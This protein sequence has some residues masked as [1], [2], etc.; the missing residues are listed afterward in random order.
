MEKD[1]IRYA[2]L[3]RMIPSH[4]KKARPSDFLFSLKMSFPS[5]TKS[6]SGKSQ[7]QFHKG[8]L[9]FLSNLLKASRAC[10][11]VGLKIS[12]CTLGNLNE[13]GFCWDIPHKICAPCS[14]YKHTWILCTWNVCLQVTLLYFWREIRNPLGV[15]LEDMRDNCSIISRESTLAVNSASW[16][17]ILS[18][19]QVAACN[20]HSS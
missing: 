8:W 9:I 17:D 5:L 20:I 15:L 16:S 12:S 19:L 18:R 1:I 13:T 6:H 3:I 10:R 14:K 7:F 11:L 4:V 2:C